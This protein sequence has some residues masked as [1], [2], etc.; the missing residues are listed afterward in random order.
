MLPFVQRARNSL[1]RGNRIL[2]EKKLAAR[3]GLEPRQNESESFVLPLHHRA[4]ILGAAELALLRQGFGEQ[5]LLRFRASADFQRE[6]GGR[7]IP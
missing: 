5:P 1:L 6:E 4:K 7:A 2:S 3:L